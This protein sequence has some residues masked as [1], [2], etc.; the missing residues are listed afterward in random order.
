MQQSNDGRNN[1]GWHFSRLHRNL[2]GDSA[3]NGVLGYPS[4]SLLP[5]GNMAPNVN[6]KGLETT[7]ST[8]LNKI[9]NLDHPSSP[10][11]IIN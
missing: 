8:C 9:R 5:G 6:W 11:K 10:R 3:I 2:L 1:K 4:Y 7:C